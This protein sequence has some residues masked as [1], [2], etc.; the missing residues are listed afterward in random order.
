MEALTEKLVF[1]VYNVLRITNEFDVGVLDALLLW[2]DAA[3]P[4]AAAAHNLCMHSTPVVL[5]NRRW[6][7]L[8][9][10]AD[11]KLG[12][13]HADE[14]LVFSLESVQSD[15]VVPRV[16]F[17]FVALDEVPS[18]DKVFCNVEYARPDD[19]HS[20][21]VPRHAPVHRLVQCIRNPVFDVA[22]VEN[23]IVVVVLAR[24]DYVLH[25]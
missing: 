23:P 16:S 1:N 3:A 11:G 4:V 2:P 8:D 20:N 18:K 25:S 19:T 22:K 21:V 15:P 10:V 14:I 9:K 24:E 13:L 5:S 12:A 6:G 7:M 17:V